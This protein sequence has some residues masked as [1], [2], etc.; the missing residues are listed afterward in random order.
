MARRHTLPGSPK[1]P[2]SIKIGEET[3]CA[4]LFRVVEKDEL[5]RAILCRVLRD[6]EIIPLNQDS[7]FLVGFMKKGTV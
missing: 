3:F 4:T 5:G 1:T 6:D 2:V 7:D